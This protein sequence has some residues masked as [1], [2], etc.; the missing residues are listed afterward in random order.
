MVKQVIQGEEIFGVAEQK[1]DNNII[2]L[3]GERKNGMEI[4]KR[5]KK[6]RKY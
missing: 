5:V 6:Y 3:E 2:S 1:I 4:Y